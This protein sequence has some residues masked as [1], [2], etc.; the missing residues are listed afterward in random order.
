MS[1]YRER[2][3]L[4]GLSV[5]SPPGRA[6][7]SEACKTGFPCSMVVACSKNYFSMSAHD[8]LPFEDDPEAH[9]ELVY[10]TQKIHFY[11]RD[12]CFGLQRSP[13]REIQAQGSPPCELQLPLLLRRSRRAPRAYLPKSKCCHRHMAQPHVH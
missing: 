8:T 1:A 13:K 9:W 12:Q 2:N 5:M 3:H 6:A 10:L 4:L 7:G 11:L